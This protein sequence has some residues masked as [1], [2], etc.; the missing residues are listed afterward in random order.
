MSLPGVVCNLKRPISCARGAD[1]CLAP[2][3]PN[4]PWIKQI[5]VNSIYNQMFKNFTQTFPATK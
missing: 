1:E 2:E 5:I 4:N 3:L